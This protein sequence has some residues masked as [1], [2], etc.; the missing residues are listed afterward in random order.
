MET[1]KGLT[2]LQLELLKL[3]RFN[4][5]DQQ[6]KEVRALLSKYFAEKAT[7]EMDKL[8]EEQG[9]SDET[10]KEWSREHLRTKYES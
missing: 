9:W 8:W 5:S 1:V 10:M 3:F 2:N 7:Q 6:I 4:L